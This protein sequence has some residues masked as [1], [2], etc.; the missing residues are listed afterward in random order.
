MPARRPADARQRL[1]V[2]RSGATR[3]PPARSALASSL[4]VS[5]PYAAAHA[6][7]SLRPDPKLTG[8]AWSLRPPFDDGWRGG[9]Y[10]ADVHYVKSVRHVDCKRLLCCPVCPERPGRTTRRGRG[11]GQRFC[12]PALTCWW[13]VPRRTLSLL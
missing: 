3:M 7:R 1:T 13:N 4:D 8:S 10:I 9:A 11:R 6:V 2:R 5:T 12:K